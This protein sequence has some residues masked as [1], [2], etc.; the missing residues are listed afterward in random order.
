[1]APILQFIASYPA[2]TFAC[3]L[4]LAVGFALWKGGGPER[5]VG[6]LFLTAF[7]ASLVT[8]SPAMVQYFAVELVA[9]L[10]DILLLVALA[11]LARA[12]NRRWT[13]V[14]AGLQLLI[15][16]AHAARAINIR[17]AAFVYMVMTAV[18]P[19]LQILLLAIGTVLHWRRMSRNGDDPAW[20]PF[21]N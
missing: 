21:L 3:V 4:L 6:L 17:Q 15:L 11:L 5:V 16:A 10:I 8:D 20:K 19:I 14:A 7:L 1:V 2:Y 12:A 9:A 18:W 13:V